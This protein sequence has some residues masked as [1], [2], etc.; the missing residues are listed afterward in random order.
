MSEDITIPDESNPGE[1][2]VASSE[3]ESAGAS[4]VLGDNEVGVNASEE[5]LKIINE[6]TGRDYKSV[7]IA[8]KSLKDNLSYV[9]QVGKFKPQLDKLREIYGSSDNV[10]KLMETLSTMPQGSDPEKPEVPTVDTSAVDALK[11][12]VD[13]MGFYSEN[14]DYK[15]YKQLIS[16]FGDNP[17]E[18]VKSED[19]IGVFSKVKAQDEAEESKSVLHSNNRLGNVTD[20][21][22]EARTA[23]K[24][25]NQG[26]AES[27]AMDAVLESMK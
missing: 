12:Q 24:E 2:D 5:A 15:P 23:L 14:P 26:Q 19:F 13:E 22:S 27:S 1:G 6:A 9:G 21:I 18:V 16:K 4:D 11:R 25:G 20:K 8:V 17:A 3:G 7:D 10:V